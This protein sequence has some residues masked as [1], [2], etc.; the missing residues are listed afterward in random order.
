MKNFR[1]VWNYSKNYRNN[2]VWGII[3]SCVSVFFVLILPQITQL[4][5][6][7]VYSI[8]TTNTSS[9]SVFWY[10][11]IGFFAN[12]TTTDIVIILCISFFVFALLKNITEY[13]ATKNF[14]RVSSEACGD[15]RA[16][17]FKKLAF[18]DRNFKPNQVFFSLT[19]DISD[20]YGVIYTIFPKIIKIILTVL[21]SVLLSFLIDWKI[22]VSFTIFIPILLVVGYYTNIKLVSIFNESRNRK[23]KMLEVG[24]VFIGEIKEI[25]TFGIEEFALAKYNKHNAIHSKVTKESNNYVHK[26]TLLLN[27]IRALG[28]TLTIVL[29]S[30]ACFDGTLT[31]GYFVLIIAYAFYALNNTIDFVGYYYGLGVGY[32]GVARLRRFLNQKTAIKQNKTQKVENPSI[33]LQN[34]KIDLNGRKIFNGLNMTFDFGKSYG[35][36]MRQGEG[37]T[38]FAKMLLRFLNTTSGR[39]YFDAIPSESLDISNL[40]SQFS[41]ISQEPY[42]FQD[43]IENNILMFEEE[44]KERLAKTIK[45]CELQKIVDKF[46]DKSKHNLEEKGVNLS[47][48][49]K[50]KINFARAIYHNAPILLIDS[51]FNKFNKTFTQKM[52]KRFLKLYKNR[53]VIILS[54]NQEDVSACEEVYYIKNGVVEKKVVKGDKYE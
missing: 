33:S 38:A 34:V 35:V 26:C 51:S 14:F 45:I 31:I 5:I 27:T 15:L 18:I 42:I 30:I 48:Q 32:I 1:F 17:C 24:E 47:S 3:L 53:T 43:T 52:I 46:S 13:Y 36:L 50:Q 12:I 20:F 22:A 2:I 11:L 41:Y 54:K 23:S 37:K 7:S 8:S 39:I 10:W 44:D 29:A 19:S 16:D 4:F 28:L 25:K 49:D 40:R 9:L 6:D 21:L